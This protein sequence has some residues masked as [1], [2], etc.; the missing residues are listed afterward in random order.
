MAMRLA[1]RAG[2]MFGITLA[3]LMLAFP[4]LVAATTN[5]P[6]AQTG[7]M[8]AT[9][10]LLG[11]NLTV[12]V[13]LNSVGDVS[14]VALDP[15]GTLTKTS[16]D[17][18]HMVKFSNAD[19]SVKVSVRAGGSSLTIRAKSTLADLSGQSTWAAD[20]FGT[21]TKSTVKY[22]IGSNGGLPTLTI[23]A[24][25]TP[26]GVTSAV[27][28]PV[29]KASGDK[30]KDGD[31]AKVQGDRSWAIGG[32]TFTSGGYTKHLSISVFAN[33]SDGTA[34]VTIT[35]SGRDKLDL[36]GTLADL[37]GPRTWVAHM[38]DGTKVSVAYHVA[39]DGSVVFDSATPATFMEK[40]FDSSKLFD[41]WKDSTAKVSVKGFIVRFDN[42]GVGVAA[43]LK[44]NGDGTFTLVVQGSSGHC[45]MKDDPNGKGDPNGFGHDHGG[46]NGSDKD[47]DQHGG[48]GG[49]RQHG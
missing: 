48:Q 38:C 17:G 35:L 12:G 34:A 18:T 31:K 13:T 27:V 1:R 43:W 29:S 36:S 7:G 4:G 14:D 24:I 49:G 47:Q 21:G 41:H 45:G 26:S 37:A 2:A 46:N 32:V 44:D 6:I 30:S 23:G 8:T 11:T 9:F 33:K 22:T 20:V 3:T 19:G 25:T 42:S 40:A 5:E 16:G 15:S 28:T 10:P 39:S